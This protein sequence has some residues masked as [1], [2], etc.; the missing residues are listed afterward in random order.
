MAGEISRAIHPQQR[1]TQRKLLAIHF[2][3][4]YADGRRCD[5]RRGRNDGVYVPKRGVKFGTQ[6]FLQVESGKVLSREHFAASLDSLSNLIAV[7]VHMRGKISGH[8]VAVA[9]FGERNIRSCVG[10]IAQMW[11]RNFAYRSAVLFEVAYCRFRRVTH[12]AVEVL[13]KI[14]ASAAQ[15]KLAKRLAKSGAEILDAMCGRCRVQGISSSEQSKQDRGVGN[16]VRERAN[17]IK[18]WRKRDAA[19]NAH[20]PKC[21]LQPDDSAHR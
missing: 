8:F 3:M 11:K 9:S 5:R 16:A 2:D 12:F 14:I 1:G 13:P 19:K 15:A 4:F 10:R 6:A 17:V 18:A 20:A 21:R 7:F